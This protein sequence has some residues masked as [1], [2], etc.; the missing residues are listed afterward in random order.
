MFD[1]YRRTRESG[2]IQSGRPPDP[3]TVRESVLDAIREE[4]ESGPGGD[5]DAGGRLT[6]AGQTYVPG[7]KRTVSVWLRLYERVQQGQ[8]GGAE[9]G[10]TPLVHTR[11]RSAGP[12]N[13]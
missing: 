13:A 1:D 6:R 7:L 12:L 11:R 2:R 8:L 9:D 5:V 4:I 3:P 10:A